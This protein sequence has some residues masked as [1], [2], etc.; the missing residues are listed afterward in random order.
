MIEVKEVSN[1]KM[2]KEFLR[3]PDEL[4]KD[5]HYYVPPLIGDEKQIFSS[6]YYYYE[7]SEAVYFNAYKDG[8]IVGHHLGSAPSQTNPYV[9]LTENQKQELINIYEELIS[10]M[11]A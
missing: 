7:N 2:R 1:R 5:C 4:Y 11:E 10:K 9:A 3:F 8:N 6:K